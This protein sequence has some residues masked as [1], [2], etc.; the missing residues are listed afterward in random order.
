MPGARC[1]VNGCSYSYCLNPQRAVSEGSPG[2]DLPWLPCGLWVFL[3]AQPNY[4]AVPQL[5]VEGGGAQLFSQGALPA[6]RGA[7][8][9]VDGKGAAWNYPLYPPAAV[10]SGS[11]LQRSDI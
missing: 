7:E 6:H 9:D 11:V 3:A 1:S 2:R 10:L 4:Q 5:G 8:A